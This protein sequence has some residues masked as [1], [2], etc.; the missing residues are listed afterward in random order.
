MQRA[1]V[2]TFAM[3]WM[4]FLKIAGA[5]VLGSLFTVGLFRVVGLSPIGIVKG[6][7]IAT[8]QGTGIAAGSLIAILQSMAMTPKPYLAGAVFFAFVYVT[9]G[10]WK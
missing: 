3:A 4:E 5:A 2:H 8:I 7:L 1:R 9:S 6:G 10:Y